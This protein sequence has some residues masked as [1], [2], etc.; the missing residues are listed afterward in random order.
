[1]PLNTFQKY[2]LNASCAVFPRKDFPGG[3]DGKESACNFL[4]R[5]FNNW[6]ITIVVGCLNYFYHFL[7][8]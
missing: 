6:V 8:R 1:M 5:I 7:Y 2:E 3:S 4:E